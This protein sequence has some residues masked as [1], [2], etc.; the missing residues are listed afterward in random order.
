MGLED[1]DY[2]RE[3]AIRYSGGGGGFG[4][5]RGP[6]GPQRMVTKLVILCVILFFIDAFTPPVRQSGEVV[7]NQLFR[8]MSLKSEDVF[9]TTILT[10]PWNV[11][12]L[13]SYGFAHASMSAQSGIF[14]IAIN[15]LLL[16]QLGRMVEDHIGR[17]EFL[18]FYLATLIFAGIVFG[19]CHLGSPASVVGASGGVTA[20]VVLFAF[21]FPNQKLAL[22]GIIPVPGWLIGVLFVS[23]DFLSA[24]FNPNGLVAYE[25]HL[26][27]A[28]FAAAYF[29][30]QWRIEKWVPSKMAQG[31][32]SRKT[33]LRVHDPGDEPQ[34]KKYEQDAELA[35]QI[36]EK[37]HRDGEASLSWKERKILNRFSKRVRDKRP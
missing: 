6:G 4:A 10:A 2:L 5:N 7:S 15:M 1:R 16:W 14:H 24:L 34:D 3:E 32:F 33:H 11:Y 17:F 30:F 19:V 37:L 12:Q 28:A 22:F 13:L 26:G 29:H 31:L 23:L 35:D 36:L 20:V 25:S 8:W 27:G 18:Y 9:S 21:L